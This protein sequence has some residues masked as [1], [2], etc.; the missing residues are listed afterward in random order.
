[1]GLSEF[2]NKPV[3]FAPAGPDAA[4]GARVTGALYTAWH[5]LLSP[6]LKGGGV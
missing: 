1:M 5:L 4:P 6:H 3:N 2:H